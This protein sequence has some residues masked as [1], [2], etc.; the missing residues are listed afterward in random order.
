MTDK[1]IEE[2]NSYPTM[3]NSQPTKLINRIIQYRIQIQIKIKIEIEIKMIYCH[4]QHWFYLRKYAQFRDFQGTPSTE[5][6]WTG[7]QSFHR[8]SPINGQH[9]LRKINRLT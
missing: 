2:T 1:I 7:A 4:L 6:D 5:F 8:K 3:T 9:N